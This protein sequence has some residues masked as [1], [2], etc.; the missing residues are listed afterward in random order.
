MNGQLSSIQ[1]EFDKI[2]KLF[3]RLRVHS[4]YSYTSY[5]YHF[6]RYYAC[7]TQPVLI[8]SKLGRMILRVSVLKF[9]MINDKKNTLS[10]IS[11]EKRARNAKANA[12]A[13]I[14][15]EEQTIGIAT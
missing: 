9:M 8:Q 14:S 11:V 6:F 4:D 3:R 7:I 15:R 12:V 5:L 2:A 13:H 1:T 10:I